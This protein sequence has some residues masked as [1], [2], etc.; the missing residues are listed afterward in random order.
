M[1]K[2]SPLPMQRNKP[3]RPPRK[4]SVYGSRQGNMENAI[5]EVD[6]NGYGDMNGDVKDDKKK[7]GRSPFRLVF[8]FNFDKLCSI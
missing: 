5:S 8:Q 1:M 7:R 3:S 2:E 4:G 6:M